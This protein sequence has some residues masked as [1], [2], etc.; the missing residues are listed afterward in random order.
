MTIFK[1]RKIHDL[2]KFSSQSLLT[3]AIFRKKI[4]DNVTSFLESYEIFGDER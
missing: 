2:K 1:K 4:S 3:P